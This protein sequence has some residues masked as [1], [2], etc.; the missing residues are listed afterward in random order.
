MSQTSVYVYDD[1][2]DYDEVAAGRRPGRYYARNG[3]ENSELLEA[4]VAALEGAEAGVATASGT[5]ALLASVLAFAGR[6][7]PLVI[8]RD[9]YGGTLALARTDLAPLGYEI[10][11]VDMCDLERVARALPGAAL[12]VCETITNPLS[13]VEDIGAISRLGAAAGVPVLVDNTYASP[14]LC[15]PL[16]WGVTAVM[17]SATKYLG[18]H[19]D[20]VAGVVVGDRARMAEVRARSTRTG[21]SLGAFDAWLALRGLRTLALR[22][23]R[24][25]DN[26][27][28]L[29]RE[30]GALPGV[31]RV[32]HPCLPGSP[33]HEV[34]RRLLPAG[35]GG[36]LGFELEGGRPA[37]QRLVTGLRLVRFAASFGGLE[38]TISHPQLASH[39]SLSEA[40]RE[41]LG[42][43]PGTVR[44]SAGIEDPADILDDF[45][46]ALRM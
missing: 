31:V 18:G 13:K 38:T 39:R 9:A 2:E 30:L 25:S 28:A 37:V 20:L 12:L 24:H 26:A 10:R 27:A 35:T 45:A 15:R 23:R 32:H 7:A 46:Q 34:A 29:A 1:L 8:D 14:V 21:G 6:P 17:H 5:A 3:T 41:A 44:V 42:I 33:G 22:M 16:E 36:M 19:S 11:E 4:A 40:D 43:T